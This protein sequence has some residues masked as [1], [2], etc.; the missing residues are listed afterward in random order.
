MNNLDLTVQTPA[1]AVLQA[2]GGG[3]PDSRNN[4]E[5]IEFTAEE[6]GAVRVRVEARAVPMGGTQPYALVIR[7]PGTGAASAATAEKP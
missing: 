5:L 1:G 4:V 3:A 6:Q 7:R 2:N